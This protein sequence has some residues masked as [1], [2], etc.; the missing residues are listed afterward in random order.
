MSS[1]RERPAPERGDD[2]SIAWLLEGDPGIRW[3]TLRDLTD[4]SPDEVAAERARVAY[5][6]WCPPRLARQRDDGNFGGDSPETSWRPN[7]DTLEVIRLLGPDPADPAVRGRIER[8]RDRVR[9]PDWFGSPAYFD[10]EEEACI[11]GEVLAQG[12]FFGVPSGPLA[13]RLVREQLDDGGWNCE[14][15]TS[16]RGSFHSTIRVIE[17]LIG[18]ERAVGGAPAVAAA[19][20]RG[21]EYLL[22]RSLMR[23]LSDGRIVD[24]RFLLFGWPNRWWYD[25]LRGLDHLRDAGRLRDPRMDEALELVRS[26]RGDDGRWRIERPGPREDD[27]DQLEATG[28]PSRM[29]TL[30]AMR[31]LRHFEAA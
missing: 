14:A 1:S 27:G 15:P 11:N 4:A 30:R 25:V 3:Q 12:A 26:H 16:T 18:Y 6:G 2:D 5:E 19:R 22:D 23:R 31:V 28:A 13:E 8:V 10:G 21:E 17:G 9:W 29:I 20:E 24:E 7:L